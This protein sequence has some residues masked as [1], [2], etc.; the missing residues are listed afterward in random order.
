MMQAAKAGHILAQHALASHYYPS[1]LN[2]AVYW[3]GKGADENF[4]PSMFKLGY[5]LYSRKRESGQAFGLM[6]RA[7]QY[8]F[9][10]AVYMT[11]IF[12]HIGFGVE[13]DLS[14]RDYWLDRWADYQGFDSKK[15]ADLLDQLKEC[16]EAGCPPLFLAYLPL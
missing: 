15:R 16:K 8:G 7:A 13:R 4:A 10:R 3:L 12:Y 1:Q 11:G 9:A 2:A 5:Y 14:Q 6:L